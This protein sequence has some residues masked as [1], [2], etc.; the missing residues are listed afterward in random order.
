MRAAVT[1]LNRR[2][3]LSLL[4]VAAAG[5]PA[6]LSAQERDAVIEGAKR[7][8]RVNFANS[9]S[10][11]GFPRFVQ[12]FTARYP[13][14]DATTG[15]YSAPAGRVLARVDAEL[16]ARALTFDVLHVANLAPYLAMAQRGQL[17]GYRSPELD[18]YPPEASDRDQWAIAR[19]VGVIM[20]YNRN[21]LPPEK[22][23]KAWADLLRPEFKNRKLVIQDSAAG[24]SFNQMYLLEK[25]LGADFMRQWG[26]QEP[27]IVSTTAQLIDLLVRGEALVGATVD[28]FRAFEPDAVKAG[29]VG[30]Y[31]NEGMPL[32][33]APV[34]IFKDARNPNAARLLVDFM[35][36]A[37]GQTLLNTEIFGVYSMRRGIAAPAGQM[38][39]D[40]T[41]FMLPHDLTDY[42]RASRRFPETFDRYFKV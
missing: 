38:P 6:R 34:A 40:Q 42:E 30:V 29:I 3:V 14:I 31:P 26:K 36:S 28:H 16:K 19:I 13:F 15:L 7:E 10:A 41:K 39:L 1:R 18:A 8:G 11:A 32:A 5:V 22:A 2:Q 4:S 25:K 23:P 37:E 20:A 12:A 17:L 35:L 33:T 24:T 21:I 27:I 9:A